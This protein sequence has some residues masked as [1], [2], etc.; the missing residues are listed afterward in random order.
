MELN[1]RAYEL[2]QIWIG[3][4]DTRRFFAPPAQKD[5]IAMMM[6]GGGKGE[7]DGELSAEIFAFNLAVVSL[8]ADQLVPF[9]AVYCRLRPRPV[10]VLAEEL[11][12]SRPTF[13]KYAHLSAI[14][15][16]ADTDGIV[17]RYRQDLASLGD[18]HGNI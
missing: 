1:Q 6:G 4:L 9:I 11:H 10:R 12:I 13:Y 5:T 16:L 17:L 18:K 15:I 8:H 7:P 14:Q 2:A 3:W